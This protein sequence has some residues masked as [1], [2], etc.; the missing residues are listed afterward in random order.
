MDSIFQFD[1]KMDR[2]K[3]KTNVAVINALID[4]LQTKPIEDITVKELAEKADINR[5]TFYNNFDSV[6]EVRETLE[7]CI[8]QYIYNALPTTITI[9]NE[10]EIYEVVYDFIRKIEPR[11]EVLYKITKNIEYS[12]AIR[13]FS[14]QLKPYIER[15]LK[16]FNVNPIVV[17]YIDNCL[18][19]GIFSIIRQ[20]CGDKEMSAEQVSILLYNLIVAA[21]KVDNFKDI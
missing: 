9:N 12:S 19:N 8:G 4:L 14:E 18:V 5:K 3:R 11:K 13:H 7:N 1:K 15:N 20:W 17:S 2:R 6:E 10:I 16:E 21:I